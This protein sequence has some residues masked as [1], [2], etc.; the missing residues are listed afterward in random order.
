[1]LQTKQTKSYMGSVKLGFMS[2]YTV[3][4]AR[5][6]LQHFIAFMQKSLSIND[7]QYI[8]NNICDNIFVIIYVII[9]KN[10]EKLPC[11]SSCP[12]I[13]KCDNI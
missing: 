13:L 10:P 1:M 7:V 9:Q 3:V 6:C 12:K 11:F 8:C 5:I 2:F 4:A